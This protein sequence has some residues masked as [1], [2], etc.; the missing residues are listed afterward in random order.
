MTCSNFKLLIGTIL[1][2][3]K[4]TSLSLQMPLTHESSSLLHD[5]AVEFCAGAMLVSGCVGPDS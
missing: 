2:T 3:P 4:F 1:L 5:G